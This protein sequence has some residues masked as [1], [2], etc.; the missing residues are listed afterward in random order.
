MKVLT[1]FVFKFLYLLLGSVLV[2]QTTVKRGELKEERSVAVGV[3]DIGQ[4]K[5]YRW[6]QVTGDT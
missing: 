6:L 1:I 2:N 5:D 3:G 4:L